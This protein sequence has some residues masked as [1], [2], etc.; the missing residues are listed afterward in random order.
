MRK[1]EKMKVSVIVPAYNTAEY[2]ENMLE[3]VINQTYKNLEII[4][5]ND[6]ST[7]D[8]LEHIKRFEIMDN[9]VLCIDIPN[10]G[11][12]NARNHGIDKATG[13]K[14]F[15]WDS[16]DYIELDC[17]EQCIKFSLDKNV[18]TVLYGYSDRVDGKNESP[19]KSYL[20]EVY[21]GKEICDKLL[22]CFIG[23]SFEDV[24]QWIR[25]NISLRQTKEHTALWRIMLDAKTVKE[26][27]LRFDI[28]LSLGEDT[29]FICEYLLNT[30]KVGYLDKCFYHL[31]IRSTGA[32]MTSNSNIELMK[33]NK[34]K[35]IVARKELDTIAYQKGINL[36]KYWEGTM[37]LS[38]IQLIIKATQVGRYSVVKEYLKIQDVIMAIRNYKPVI[39]IRAVPFIFLKLRAGRILYYI[40]K[41]MPSKII[42]KMI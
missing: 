33:Q 20:K 38:A 27:G 12:S 6:G 19:H 1:L 28:N 17:I 11:V 41:L 40:I 7:D 32:N 39:G 36:H 16:D 34:M 4:V 15:F 3:C 30:Q 18:E 14:I 23:H 8:T 26:K 9:R 31:T 29:K 10:G 21:S 5:I 37:V 35:L 22:P 2:I 25:K 42:D 24:N 13:E